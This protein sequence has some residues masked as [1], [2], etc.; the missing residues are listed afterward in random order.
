[1]RERGEAWLGLADAARAA[2]A[3]GKAIT[4]FESS[5]TRTHVDLGRLHL[6]AARAARE[7][8][9]QSAADEHLARA[10]EIAAGPDVSPYWRERLEGK[11]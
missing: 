1:M 4:Y 3:C 11:I 9:E 6:C 2:S 10:R 8:G 7:L 5:L